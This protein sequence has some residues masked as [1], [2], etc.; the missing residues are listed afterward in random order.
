MKKLLLLIG[1]SL[2]LL[3][4]EEKTKFNYEIIKTDDRNPI[5][6]VDVYVKDTLNIKKIN[7]VIISEI[8]SNGDKFIMVRYF[9][10]KE[11]AKIYN[12]KIMEVSDKEADVLFKHILATYNS[13]PSTNYKKLTIN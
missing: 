4:C 2:M 13:N 9:D 6:N 1:L 5:V 7:D 3:S 12:D 10:D 8:D 11:I